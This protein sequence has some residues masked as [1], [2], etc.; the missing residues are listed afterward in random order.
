MCQS[1]ENTAPVPAPCFDPFFPLHPSILSPSFLP[2]CVFSFLSSFF[3]FPLSSFL[4]FRILLL[5]SFPFLLFLLS[6][7]LFFPFLY[8]F[9]FHNNILN[10]ARP[11]N[12]SWDHCPVLVN[13]VQGRCVLRVQVTKVG[14]PAAKAPWAGWG[15]GQPFTGWSEP[16]GDLTVPGRQRN[17]AV[18][19]RKLVKNG[20]CPWRGNEEQAAL[21]VSPT[22]T[23]DK[24]TSA[25]LTFKRYQRCQWPHSRAA[26]RSPCQG[27]W[28]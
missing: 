8:V 4:P 9:L 1:E 5:P 2:F 6:L 28:T 16:G 19:N 27:A 22:V 12:W 26:W 7:F 18:S 24:R 21:I 11:M 15:R 20:R 14:A 25:V 13:T 23:A 10:E 17:S 3:P